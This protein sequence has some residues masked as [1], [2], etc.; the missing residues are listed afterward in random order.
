MKISTF[1]L[2]TTLTFPIFCED[3]EEKGRLDREQFDFRYTY[4]GINFISA[5]NA[6]NGIA[7][8]SSL[9]LPGPLYLKFER[10]GDGINF[11]DETVDKTTD[12][13]RLGVRSGIGD[14]LGN[15]SASGVKI[16]V[17]NMF[18]IFGELGVKSWSVENDKL[19]FDENEYEANVVTGIHF[20]DSNDWEGKIF[21]DVA[22]EAKPIINDDI[23]CLELNCPTIYEISDDQN[24]RFGF[25]AIYN[26]GK[27]TAFTFGA[28][29][30][31][32]YDSTT[33]EIGFRINL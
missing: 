18:E 24:R 30:N 17:E 22:S 13:L 20:G 6:E 23:V 2:I 10:R 5:N 1:F 21:L 3:Y 7:L 28:T 16:S 4:L 12:S 25:E 32:L 26:R 9:E 29:T 31:S 33:F 19:N 15:I 8:N 11:E 27:F 14:I